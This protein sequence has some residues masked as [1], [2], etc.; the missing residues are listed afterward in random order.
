MC[1]K[2]A[3]AHSQTLFPQAF[4]MVTWYD[5]FE[6]AKSPDLGQL[7]FI[8]FSQTQKHLMRFFVL[9]EGIIHLTG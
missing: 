5:G 6:I 1:R 4:E 7:R 3:R 9:E 8:S 2:G